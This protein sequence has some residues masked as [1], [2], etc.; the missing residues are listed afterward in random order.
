MEY[1]WQCQLSSMATWPV[2]K[3]C[4]ELF[5]GTSVQESHSFTLLGLRISFITEK[6]WGRRLICRRE[7]VILSNSIWESLFTQSWYGL[8]FYYWTPWPHP[9][10]LGQG[11]TNGEIPP[12]EW[13]EI[14]NFTPIQRY[15]TVWAEQARRCQQQQ[16]VCPGD[17]LWTVLL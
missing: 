2:R 8:F 17:P 3:I 4:Q 10:T 7:W 11:T 16:A 6:Y 12:N 1:L 5:T 15:C 9:E 13:W 14:E